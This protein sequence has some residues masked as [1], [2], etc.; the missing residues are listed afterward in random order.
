VAYVRTVRTGSG[1][2]AVQIVHGS[3]RGA[4]DIEHLG[5]A[6]DAQAVE[7]LKAVARQRLAGGQGEL[8]LGVDIDALDV[9]G[10]A[11]L[12]IASSRMTPLWEALCSAYDQLGFDAATDHDEVFAQL[13]LARIIEPTS[14]ADSLRVLAEAGIDTVSYATVKRRLHS[15]A[16]DAWRR[17]LATACAAHARLGPASLVLYDVSTLY[18]ETDTGDGFREPGFSKERRLDPQITIGLLTDASG[19]P[20]MVEAFE[21]NRAETSTMVPTIRAFMTVHQLSDVTIVA[22]AGMISAGNQR[23]I[24]AAGLSF[25][26]GAR[27][28]QVPYVIT[29]WRR[30][31]PDQEIPDG[32]VLTQPW[33]ASPTDQRRDQVIYYQY[34]ADRARR[35]LRGIDEQIAKAERAVAGKVP[36]KRNRFVTLTGAD[37]AINRTLEA[38]A[39]SLAGWKGYSTNLTSVGPEFVIGAYHRLFQIERSF[40]MSKHDLAARPIYHHK[41]ASIEAHLTVVFA[42]LAVSR[43]VEDRTG[44]SIR[45]F[46]QTARRYRTVQIHAGGRWLT[47]ADPIPDDLQATLARIERPE[48][49]H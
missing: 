3:R 2:T 49:A 36:V 18:F 29:E 23:A 10:A 1:A 35:T 5:S 39:R 41:R 44:W 42:A 11:P 13:V 31:N 12:Q 45:R 24:E 46:V 17:R 34:T 28:P 25:I 47:A 30:Q 32:L 22:D 37:K 7:A 40:R 9:V 33:P 27:T 14:K 26:L 48:G 43:L 8:D 6:Q 19:F 4:R 38:K 21:G 16:D 20:L 15:Y